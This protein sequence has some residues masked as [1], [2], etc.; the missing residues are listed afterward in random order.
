MRK[1]KKKPGAQDTNV[2]RASVVVVKPV[3][4]D[5]A[6]AVAAVVVVEPGSG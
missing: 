3:G 2:S 5:G 6:I 4:G 1:K